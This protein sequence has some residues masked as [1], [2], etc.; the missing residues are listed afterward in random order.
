QHIEL[1][2]YR[3]QI[4]SQDHADLAQRRQLTGI[5]ADQTAVR[6]IHRGGQ[7]GAI[8]LVDRLDE[9]LAHTPGGAHYCNTLHSRPLKYRRR[10]ASRRRTSHWPWANASCHP[11]ATCGTLPA[12]RADACSG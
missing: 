7:L 3:I 11:P 8:C 6:T 2:Q 1:I 9:D 5:S 4:A 10:S 12:T